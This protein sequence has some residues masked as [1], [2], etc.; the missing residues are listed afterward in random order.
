MDDVSIIE[1]A[2]SEADLVIN[3]APD[4]G[5]EDGIAAII[6]GLKKRE[7]KPS[8]IQLSGAAVVWD[9]P[10]GMK[11]ERL[12]I[13]A[14]SSIHVALIAPTF[15]YGMSPSIYH[16]TP[17][18]TSWLVNSARSIG[19]AFTIGEGSNIQG[20]IHI[21]DLSRIYTLLI[22]QALDGTS[23]VNPVFWGPD[24]YYFIA[25]EEHNYEEFMKSL[26]PVLKEHGIVKT[27]QV[28]RMTVEEAVAACS[29]AN[30][31]FSHLAK[32]TV[33]LFGVNMRVGCS[34]ARLLG[35]QPQG[36]PVTATLN[37]MIGEYVSN[38]K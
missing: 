7:E 37:E 32:Y 9:K 22:N 25:G 11:E 30:D 3:T 35:W 13:G 16:P 34:R 38:T 28:R 19:S 24:A 15:V 4:I 10:T 14:S 36:A 1:K 17:M 6:A 27:E 12:L 18:A 21:D 26:A 2:A 29:S 23:S 31:A 5:N 8:Y 33:V 20:F